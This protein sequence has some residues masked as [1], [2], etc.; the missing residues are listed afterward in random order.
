MQLLADRLSALLNRPVLNRS[1]VEGNFEFT[2]QFARDELQQDSIP[3]IF[4]AVQEQLGLRLE[5]TKGIIETLV[6]LDAARPQQN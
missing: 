2:L 4:T 5:R 1:A 6:I 3:S